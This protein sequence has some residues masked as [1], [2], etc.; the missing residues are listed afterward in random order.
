AEERFAEF[1]TE[2]DIVKNT[3]VVAPRIRWQGMMENPLCSFWE[4]ELSEVWAGAE[5]EKPQKQSQKQTSL[6]E[7][8]AKP[9]A[10]GWLADDPEM[11][12]IYPISPQI[13]RQSVAI[14]A[15]GA[16]GEIRYG[17]Q[18]TYQGSAFVIMEHKE[19]RL[20]WVRRLA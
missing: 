8:V 4:Q 3:Y 15:M 14:G 7:D 11:K 6:F 20:R 12:S 9:V 16:D 1:P 5:V 10:K 2:K 18:N 19:T 17:E 13:A